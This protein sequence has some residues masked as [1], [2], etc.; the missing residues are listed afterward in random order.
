MGGRHRRLSSYAFPGQREDVA[1]EARRRVRHE[2]HDAPGTRFAE[3]RCPDT[4]HDVESG[5][6]VAQIA[7]SAGTRRQGSGDGRARAR[8]GTR[9]IVGRRH[10][11]RRAH[12]DA[13]A[14]GVRCAALGAHRPPREVRRTGRQSERLAS[15]RLHAVADSPPAQSSRRSAHVAEHGRADGPEVSLH[16][17]GE[18]RRFVDERVDQR[19]VRARLSSSRLGGQYRQEPHARGV[20]L[21][22]HPGRSQGSAHPAFQ[23]ASRNSLSFQFA[24]EPHKDGMCSQSIT[25]AA[26]SAIDADSTIDFSGLPHYAEM[27]NLSFFVGS[28]FPFTKYADLAQTAVV[29]SKTP[30]TAELETVFS[31]L[32][33][34]GRSTGVYADRFE[35]LD[36]TQTD[37]FKDR[38][39]LMVG[40]KEVADL[41]VKWGKNLPLIIDQTRRVMTAQP[42]ASQ[43]DGVIGSALAA[44]P[45]GPARMDALSKGPLAALIGFESPVTRSR[46]VVAIN[47]SSDD[48]L[49][50]VVNAIDDNARRAEIHGDLAVFSGERA[51]SFRLGQRYFVGD[52]SWWTR[53]RFHLSSHPILVGL[54]A[55]LA[56]FAIALKCFGW[57][58]RRAARRLEQ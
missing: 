30:D 58:Q 7:G 49:L 24:M 9:R 41:L 44:S 22:R 25:H 10:A 14:R 27:P 56:A 6:S 42:Q 45:V 23:V 31:T 16:A 37:R 39:L 11:H 50:G 12:A 19:S 52:V 17:A 2:R 4:A 55:L 54:V 13:T 26:R 51:D 38:D 32:G 29:M 21:G 53:I 34:F 40:G 8:L 47:A 35:V 3:G 20:A 57:L 1:V 28:G 46:S 18:A 15:E 5:R 43:G 48:A 36:T 33:Q